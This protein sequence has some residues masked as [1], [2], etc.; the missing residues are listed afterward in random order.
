MPNTVKII[1]SVMQVSLILLLLLVSI[2]T[3]H[4]KGKTGTA[5]LCTMLA[6]IGVI[7]YC[8]WK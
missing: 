5:L 8:I 7:I 3:T 6:A 1:V 4:Y 2:D